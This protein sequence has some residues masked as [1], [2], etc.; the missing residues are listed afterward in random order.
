MNAIKR[1]LAPPVF[2]DDQ[3]KTRQASLVNMIGIAC[4]AFILIVVAGSML[5]G[6]TPAST[7]IIDFS[8]S[9]MILQ[10]LRWLRGG[11]VTLA[12]VGMVIFGLVY[13]TGVT[14]SVGTI[15]TPT[16]AIFV[17]WVLMTGLLFDLRGILIGTIAASLA[18]WGLI[19]AENAGWLRQPF[20]GVGVTQWVTFTAL[21][22]FTSGLTYY[23]IQGTK[24][25]LS[26]AEKEIEERKLTEQA[27]SRSKQQYDQLVSKIPVGAYILKSRQDGSFTLDYVSPRAAELFN[28]SVESLLVDPIA[29][30]QAIHPADR[31]AFIKL[32]QL[33]IEQ[34]RPFEWSGRT[35]SEGKVKFLRIESSPDPQENGEVLWH[36]IVEDITERKR[37]EKEKEQ[38]FRF[39]TLSTD[40]MGIADPFGCFKQVNPALIQLTGYSESELVSKPFLDF[41]HPEDRQRTA[42]EM[43]LQVQVRPSLHFENRYVC[44]DGSVILLSWTAF[45]DMNDGTTYATARDI[46]ERKKAEQLLM[47]SEAHLRAIVENEPEC[48]KI[49]DAQ[50]LLVQMN[51]AGLAMIEADSLAQV[52]GASV[53]G[54][55]VPEYREAFM[56]MHKRVMA[57]QA[58]KMEFEM[59]GLQGGRR[60]METHAV[61]MKSQGQ[62]VH[63]AVTRDITQRKQMEEQVRQL[64]F[65]DTLTNL[66]NRRLL[67]DRL[68]QAMAASKRNG[69]YC[70]LISLDLDNFK[71]LNDTHGHEAGDLLLIEVAKR[72]TSSVREVDTVSRFGGDEFSVLLSELIADKTESA[73]EVGI[74]AEKIRIKLAE[75]YLLTIRHAGST[76]TTVKHCCSASIGVVVFI[77]H[78]FSQEDI[79]RQADTAMY[80]AKN[81]GRNTVVF[82]KA[83]DGV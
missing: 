3:E 23:I 6:K 50:G 73:K 22:A 56:E 48:I 54:L 41:V 9:A 10:F 77:N 52:K 58:Q 1:W 68:N 69:C 82:H 63:L 80:Q 31:D 27:L 8:G 34:M 64:A 49:I 79:L 12:R 57:G 70:A 35:Q 67:L 15:R 37:L 59:M 62:T 51:P 19:V 18:V 81:A 66:P 39:F 20:Q 33:G 60:W 4:I 7:L 74:I 83:I 24:R 47:E 16:A 25:A 17:F 38:Y 26:L 42:D 76:V 14:A 30:T 2:E 46:T 65:H 21:F 11:R 32:N 78:Q 5:E 61:P 28:A 53:L 44:R 45:F 36:G 72:L 13:L 75:P 71:L 55:I 43:K 40:A 29:W